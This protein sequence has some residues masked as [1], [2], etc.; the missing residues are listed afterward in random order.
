VT[1]KI[2]DALVP[3]EADT[4]AGAVPAKLKPLDEPAT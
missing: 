3:V 4:D 2:E 1:L